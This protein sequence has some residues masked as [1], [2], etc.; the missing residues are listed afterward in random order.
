MQLAVGRCCTRGRQTSQ[1]DR[2][3]SSSRRRHPFGTAGLKQY[4]QAVWGLGNDG[5]QAFVGA[6]VVQLL[7]WPG[8]FAC[9]ADLQPCCR[10]PEHL[11]PCSVSLHALREL[12]SRVS[13]LSLI[14]TDNQNTSCPEYPSPVTQC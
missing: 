12:L 4:G 7:P 9:G 6:V 11:L 13:L 2:W 10:V 5:S 14:L 8:L 3:T 1:G